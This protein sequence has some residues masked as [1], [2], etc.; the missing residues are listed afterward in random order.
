[1]VVTGGNGGKMAEDFLEEIY[2]EADLACELKQVVEY[3]KIHDEYHV[4]EMGSKLLPQLGEVCKQYLGW[5]ITRGR[6]LWGAVQ[7]L[8]KVDDDLILRGDIIENKVLPL[9]EEKIRQ[10]GENIYV[11]NEEGDYAFESSASGFLT[12][13]DLKKN[14]Y[15]HSSVNPMWEARKLAEYIFEPRKKEYVIWGCG[16]GY[17]I[18]Q[19]YHISGDTVSIRVYER[20]ARIIEY[21][22]RYG[23]LDWIPEEKLSVVI[24]PDPGVFLHNIQKEDIGFYILMPELYREKADARRVLEDIY[25]DYTTPRKFKMDMEVNYWNNYRNG[26]KPVSE[27]DSSALKKEFIVVAAGPSLDENLEFLRKNKGNKTLIAVGTVFRKLLACSIVPDIVVILDPQERIY[28]QIEGLETQKVPMLVGESAY[29]K[30]AANYQGDKY[31]VPL[32]ETSNKQNKDIWRIGG[33]VTHLAI[34]AAGRFGAEKIYLIGVDLSFPA[35]VSHADGTQDR[36]V[37]ALEGLVPIEGVGNTTVYAD[38]MFISY[39]KW[40]EKK[41]TETPWITYYNMSRIGAKIAGTQSID[42]NNF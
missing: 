16:L 22:Y 4:V 41:I 13:K 9:L 34:E 39:R 32:L 37:K 6:E 7:N 19:L 27:F 29:W 11:E 21:A 20:D 40:I 30:I 17:L 1:M 5:D 14:K 2:R 8:I 12:L 3:A 33:T 10:G 31:L 42:G 24:D 15:I 25:M 23:V 26:C 35:G 36:T 18:Y 28:R 38:S